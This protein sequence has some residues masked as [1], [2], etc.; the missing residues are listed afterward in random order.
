MIKMVFWNCN[1]IRAMKKNL[2]IFAAAIAAISAFTSCNKEIDNNLGNEAGIPFSITLDNSTKTG[3]DDAFH[4]KWVS[5]DAVNLFYAAANSETY[6]SAGKFTFSEGSVFTG[7][8]PSSLEEGGYDWYASYP[9]NSKL[10]SPASAQTDDAY[11]YIGNKNGI[12]QKA[13][14]SKEHLSGTNCPLYAVLK[15][16]DSSEEVSMTM[17]HISSV[18]EITVNNSSDKALEIKSVTFESD[19][20]IVGSYYIDYSS[21]EA[22]CTASGANYVSSKAL[23]AVTESSE[24]AKGA[25]AKFYIPIKAHTFTAA[26]DKSIKIT[27][28]GYEKTIAP[29]KDLVFSAGKIKKIAFDYDNKEDAP[30]V[31]YEHAGTAEDPY[32][33]TDA[34]KFIE[35]LY[36][37]TSETV[38]VKGII[39]QIK[40]VSTQYGNADYYISDDGSTETEQLFVYRGKYLDNAK[41][42]AA[43]QIAV[44][45][46]VVITGKLKEYNGTKEF[47]QGNY[48]VSIKSKICAKPVITLEGAVASITCSTEGAKIYYTLDGTDPTDASQLYKEPVTLTDGQT[49]KAI[50]YC[51]GLA[52]SAVVSE[53]YTAPT[54]GDKTL[55]FG[56][57]YNNEKVSSYTDSWT[58]TCDGFTWNMAN[59]NNNNNGNGEENV[60]TE[61]NPQTPWT[62]VKAGRKKDASVATI[63]TADVIP[64]SIA[65]VTMTFSALKNID[66]INSFKLEV[67]EGE[68]VAERVDG[69]CNSLKVGDYT[70]K[71]LEPK[72]NCKYKI[73]FDIAI[74]GSNGIIQLD[75]VVY[76][77]K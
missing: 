31:E 28:N 59:W 55:L 20:D 21:G 53:S 73:T 63:E 24:L 47:D 72:A 37:A 43:D 36:G 41:F 8:L 4:T 3:I 49:I 46:E 23:L 40:S 35:T 60:G 19:Q 2:R 33:V 34:L 26:A 62:F 10:K 1:V 12:A 51:T 68:T 69:D 9:Y 30:V 16:L 50:A 39:A 11:I 77:G 52:P 38:Y 74:A 22:V 27:V 48:I 64:S 6:T 76:S 18:V 75:K 54:A 32:S 13:N 7:T 5:G 71:I 45:D 44:G 65:S 42:T 15:G 14:D 61:K 66:K 17:K 70:F 58:V 25:S 57:Q 29:A 67:Y 56:A